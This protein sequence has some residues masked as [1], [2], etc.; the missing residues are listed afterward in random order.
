MKWEL[1][2]SGTAPCLSTLC[3][4]DVTA[5]DQISQAFL[6]CICILQANKYWNK[7]WRWERRHNHRQLS[8][9]CNKQGHVS[10]HCSLS[11][12]VQR[13]KEMAYPVTTKDF[14]YPIPDMAVPF[15]TSHV[16]QHIDTIS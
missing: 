9:K 12:F 3:L 1:Y 16:I 6:P 8:L 15:F 11:P 5:C 14:L 10:T 4:P 13:R 7:Y 2:M